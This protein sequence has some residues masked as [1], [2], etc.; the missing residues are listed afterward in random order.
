METLNVYA[1]V[2]DLYKDFY[3]CAVKNSFDALSAFTDQAEELTGKLLE[4]VPSLPEESKKFTSLY[5]GESKKGQ[6]LL[7]KLV[8]ANLDID[9]M[10]KEAPLKSLEALED[11]SKG[12]FKEATAVQKEVKPLVEFSEEVVSSGSDNLQENVIQG[13]ETAKKALSEVPA[14]KK[15][16]AAK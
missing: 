12:V 3:K 9:W 8:E 7:K 2:M 10:A 4:G 13:F 14:S 5:F 11:F 6:A 15:K 1:P 16:T